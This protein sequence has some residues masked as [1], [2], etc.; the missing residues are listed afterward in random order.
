M[1]SLGLL[2]ELFLLDRRQLLERQQRHAQLIFARERLGHLAEPPFG[3][4]HRLLRA[5]VA[6][7][8]RQVLLDPL[9]QLTALVLPA[10]A[11][12]REDHDAVV[13]FTAGK[14]KQI[15]LVEEC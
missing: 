6:V 10:E 9:G 13:G 1:L 2:F 15:S 4:L 8:V 11:L 7:V 14:G 12:V 5:Q 3:Q